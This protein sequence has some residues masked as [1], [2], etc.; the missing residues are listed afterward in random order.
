MKQRRGPVSLRQHQG[1]E[2]LPWC[3]RNIGPGS[4]RYV[5]KCS[6]GHWS[7]FGGHSF[8]PKSWSGG[9][10]FQIRVSKQWALLQG[11]WSFP[12]F[13][14]CSAPGWIRHWGVL[15]GDSIW[16]QVSLS[17]INSFYK[18]NRFS[19]TPLRIQWN[20]L[21]LSLKPHSFTCFL[22]I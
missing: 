6:W 19:P 20:N 14:P 1:Y 3:R 4:G 9:S 10:H 5:A 17:Q 11:D 2:S 22:I 21:S 8:V 7:H 13:S 18:T 16:G 15:A 12:H